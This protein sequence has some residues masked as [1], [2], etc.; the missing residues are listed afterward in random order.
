LR[1]FILYIVDFVAFYFLFGQSLM[2]RFAPRSV[3]RR[4][5]LME[6]ERAFLRRFRFDRDL[7]S[8]EKRQQAEAAVA[9]VRAA[10][11]GEENVEDIEAFL[12]SVESEFVAVFPARTGGWVREYFEVFVVVLAIVFGFRAL[13]LQ[14]FKIPTGSMQ[15]TLFGIHFIPEP[16]LRQ[17]PGPVSRFFDYLHYS[18]RYVDAVV[19]KSGWL[20]SVRRDPGPKIPVLRGVAR[21]LFPGTI[22]RIAGIDYHLPGA[23]ENVV[24]YCKHLR[25]AIE[26]RSQD[27]PG[28][29]DVLFFQK[30]EVLARGYLMLGDHLFVNRLRYPFSEPRRGDITV[31]HTDGIQDTDGR[32]LSASGHYYIKRLVG[33]PGDTLR[34]GADHRLYLRKKG[35]S[36]FRL[37]DASISPAFP[38]LYSFKGGYHGYGHFPGS[39]YLRTP[40]DTFT[41]PPDTYFMLGDNSENSKDSRFWGTVPRR[42]L[43]GTAFFVWWPYSRRWGPVD[44]AEPLPFA[45]PATMK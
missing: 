29:A 31:F 28:T 45:S 25:A 16:D 42:N 5:V 14:P 23:P 13:F 40:R 37:V 38:R 10:R 26:S 17:V 39:T 34:I 8:P 6:Y 4:R 36:E 19:E 32:P 35:E 3:R 24:G 2:R 11:T 15:P 44:H 33:L 1:H 41:V 30:G 27:A 18:R 43:V 12:Q 21:Y 9:R 20:E 7:L 22:V